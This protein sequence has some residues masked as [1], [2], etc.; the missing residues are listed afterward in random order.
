MA[1]PEHDRRHPLERLLAPLEPV[2][3]VETAHVE[4]T[5]GA[6]TPTIL[7]PPVTTPPQWLRRG[8]WRLFV[9]AASVAE[10]DEELARFN[11]TYGTAYSVRRD[12]ER[13]KVFLP[14]SLGEA[15]HNYVSEAWRPS[16]RQRRLS[17]SQLNAFYRVKRFVPR[18]AQ[19]AGRRLLMRWQGIPDFPSWPLDRS[20][21][22]LVRLYAR[23]LLSATGRTE[24]RFRWFW[25]SDYRAALILTHD[26]ESEEGLR[27]ATELA[28][29]E[30]E[31]GLRSSFNLVASDYPIDH[32]I[33]REL[34]QRG[35]ELGVHGV[36]HDRSMFSSRAAFDAQQPVVRRTAAE[37]GAEGFRSPA[38]HRVF[39]WLADLPVA[40]DC[41]I[42][43]ADPFEPQPG[44]CCSIWPFFIGEVLE[45]PYTMPQDHTLF[46]LLRHRSPELWVNQMD[47]IEAEF[48]LVQC[49]SHPDPGY[50][51]DS[52]KRALYAEF[53]DVIATRT[54]LWKAL[55]REVSG[56]WRERDAENLSAESTLHG[57]ISIDESSDNVKFEPPAISASRQPES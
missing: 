51:G 55:P 40:Y 33:V 20:V 25:P 35:F 43:H 54:T 22:K 13:Q 41:S 11:D 2:R 10:G 14:F 26:V 34:R 16:V 8:E 53:L 36:H 19:L 24:A 17:A 18:Q 29:L 56:W 5:D 30:E 31:R 37:L 52:E 9:R 49:V 45:L 21:A 38:T 50:L 3:V 44:G 12:A 1:G 27:L 6:S 28:D 47:A 48:G 7:S 39:E 15:F 23:C 42:P 4:E 32:G 57:R 46:T